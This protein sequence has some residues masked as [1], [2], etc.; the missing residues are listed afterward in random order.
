MKLAVEYYGEITVFVFYERRIFQELVHSHD[1]EM[2]S[3]INSKRRLLDARIIQIRADAHHLVAPS[4]KSHDFQEGTLTAARRAN[5]EQKWA[6]VIYGHLPDRTKIPYHNRFF[7]SLP[8]YIMAKVAINF[9]M[10]KYE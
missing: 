5:K 9:G 1:F 4:Q 6:Q 8:E 3:E 2:A 10:R 7:H